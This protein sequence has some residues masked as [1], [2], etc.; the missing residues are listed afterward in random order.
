M[1]FRAREPEAIAG[2]GPEVFGVGFGQ[3]FL[4]FDTED[5]DRDPGFVCTQA[6]LVKLADRPIGVFIIT[7]TV[8][9]IRIR[10]NFAFVAFTILSQPAADVDGGGEFEEEDAFG[11]E[12]NVDDEDRAFWGDTWSRQRRRVIE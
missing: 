3:V 7:R 11:V 12:V 2:H 5:I 4:V 1:S 10:N 9:D 8:S 6:D